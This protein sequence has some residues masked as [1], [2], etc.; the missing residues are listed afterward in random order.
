ML[1]PS[2]VRQF[3]PI[4][5]AYAD[6][7]AAGPIAIH[8]NQTTISLP[9]IPWDLLSQLVMISCEVFETE[10]KVLRLTGDHIVIG[11]LHGHLPNLLQIIHDFG[12]PPQTR[13]LFL[14]DIIG[15]GAFS[16]ETLALILTMKVIWSESVFLVRSPDEV[17]PGGIENVSED[18]M[19]LWSAIPFAAIVN[20]TQFCFRGKIGASMV[21]EFGHPIEQEKEISPFLMGKEVTEFGENVNIAPVGYG[22]A[23]VLILKENERP[24]LK[25]LSRL[26]GEED[27]ESEPQWIPIGELKSYCITPRKKEKEHRPVVIGVP[28]GKHKVPPAPM[29]AR[30]SWGR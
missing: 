6:V 4:L 2:T 27:Y 5:T 20:R 17:S 3:V 12:F 15:H 9:L 14:G 30:Y 22:N 16:L 26:N 21:I 13:Y 8:S 24:R 10:P 18:F 23:G 25:I 11:D 29:M 1:H 28:I 7:I 19:Q